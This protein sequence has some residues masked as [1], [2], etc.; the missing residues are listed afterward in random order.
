MTL[1]SELTKLMEE[2]KKHGGAKVDCAD[3]S[4]ALY[5]ILDDAEAEDVIDDLALDTEPGV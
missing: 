4:D 5:N 1:R 2:L 3:M